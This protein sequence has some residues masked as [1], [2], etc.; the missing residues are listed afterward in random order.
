M[1]EAQDLLEIGRLI[2]QLIEGR[3]LARTEDHRLWDPDEERWSQLG[4]DRDYWRG[5]YN[6]LVSM[7]LRALETV[8]LQALEREFRPNP[9]AERMPLILAVAGGACVAGVVLFFSLSAIRHA[10]ERRAKEHREA[11]S[12]WTNHISSAVR[13]LEEANYIS[14]ESEFKSAAASVLKWKEPDKSQVA[15]QGL[16]LTRAL[17]GADRALKVPDYE[18]AEQAL[19]QYQ[20]AARL[21]RVFAHEAITKRAVD[22]ESLSEAAGS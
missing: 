6:K 12:I 16:E 15:A 21:S 13:F 5:W 22:G 3:L 11:L 8:N 14:A 17:E 19:K 9:V 2:L 10:Q 7:D 20:E 4:K 18:E 1:I